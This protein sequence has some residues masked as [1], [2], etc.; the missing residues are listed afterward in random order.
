M[1]ECGRRPQRALEIARALSL[2]VS[3]PLGLLFL[4]LTLSLPPHSSKISSYCTLHTSVYEAVR[5][6]HRVAQ[7]A[8]SVCSGVGSLLGRVHLDA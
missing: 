7:C 2:P 8:M 6:W 1:V 4:T 3:V 5:Q